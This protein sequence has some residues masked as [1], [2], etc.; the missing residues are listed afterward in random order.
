MADLAPPE[1]LKAP[2][3]P[4]AIPLPEP[5]KKRGGRPRGS[6]NR[7][8]RDVRIA[9]RKYSKRALVIIMKLAED[10][11]DPRTQLAAA[12]ELLDRAHGKPTMTRLVGGTGED[13][14]QLQ[15]V[16]DITK[17]G[18]LELARRMEVLL[19]TA[20]L[21]DVVG[22]ALDAEADADKPALAPT[23]P[24]GDARGPGRRYRES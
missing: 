24:N 4:E 1:T 10:S 13:P 14:V 23:P 19:T 5:K 12:V 3:A 17:G 8:T 15:R 6:V 11:E 9:A 22:K 21:A 7:C 18:S 16:R 20:G 2:A